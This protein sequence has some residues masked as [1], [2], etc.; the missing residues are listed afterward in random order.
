MATDQFGTTQAQAIAALRRHRMLII[1][2][3]VLAAAAGLGFG[4]LTSNTYT[5]SAAVLVNPLEGNPY[6]PQGRGDDLLNL[7]TEAQL[8]KTDGVA[9]LARTRMRSTSYPGELRA[10]VS[11]QVPPNTQVLNIAFTAGDPRR[12][13]DGA[14]AF[15]ESYLEYRRQRTQ[16]LLDGKLK[17]LADSSHRVELSLQAATRKAQVSSGA[18][19]S[20]WETRIQAYTNQLGVIEEQSNDVRSTPINPGQV[21]T[22]A[23]LPSGPGVKQPLT[24]G[25]VGL[26][27]GLALAVAIVL[28][29]QRT[30][31]RLYSAEEVEQLGVPVLSTLQRPRSGESQ[32]PLVDLPKGGAGDAYRKLRAA[33]VAT[34]PK[35]PVT[36]LVTSATPNRSATLVSANLAV[37]LAFAGSATILVDAATCDVDPAPL[38]RLRQAKGLSDSLLH[39]VDPAELLVHVDSQL[40][41]LPRGGQAREAA[42]RFSGPRMREAIKVLRRRAGFLVV[43]ADS[44]SDA[45]AQ[46]LCVM[47]DAVLLI[48]TPGVT[49]RDELEQAYAEAQRAN[50]MVIGTVLDTPPPKKGL[51]GRKDSTGQHPL[52]PEEDRADAAEPAD[53]AASEAQGRTAQ[54]R[55]KAI[56]ALAPAEHD[57]PAPRSQPTPTRS[58]QEVLGEADISGSWGDTSVA[59]GSSPRGETSSQRAA[60]P[61]NHITPAKAIRGAQSTGKRARQSAPAGHADATLLGGEERMAEGSTSEPAG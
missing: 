22:P 55:R 36:L 47:A 21:I 19:R 14:Q 17:K 39:G 43:N 28:I 61:G 26:L 54:P 32:L 33:V 16:S 53:G 58:S 5:A 15:A 10:R 24:F 25:G 50:T 48:I 6:S 31:R 42:H 27:A 1:V 23:V 13:R 20:F 40:R 30:E 45:D 3:T 37:A 49:T 52:P 38:F 59:G 11:V 29:R 9:Q 7:E 12:A 51:R 8:V 56:A 60:Q 41:L 46:A 18:T 4:V 57:G 34:A 35:A 44:V 2:I